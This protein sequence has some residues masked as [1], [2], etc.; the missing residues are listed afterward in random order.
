MVV[1]QKLVIYNNICKKQ[2]KMFKFGN[3]KL[4]QEFCQIKYVF[5]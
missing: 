5:L 1:R 2:S 4:L 3:L